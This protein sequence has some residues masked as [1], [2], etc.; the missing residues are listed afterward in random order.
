MGFLDDISIG[1]SQDGVRMV[2]AGVEKIGKTTLVSGAP[3]AIL[4]PLEIGY[5]TVN[6][7]KKPMVKN[8]DHLLKELNEILELCR[9]NQFPFQSIIFDSATALERLIHN[10][11]LNIDPELKKDLSQNNV[12]ASMASACGGFGKAYIRASEMMSNFLAICDLLAVQYKINIIFTCHVASTN[13]ID[14]IS[15]EYDSWDLVLHSNKKGSGAKAILCQWTDLLGFMHEPIHVVKANTDKGENLNKAVSANQGRVLSVTRSPAYVAGNRFNM[16]DDIPI[17]ITN[18]WNELAHSI[19][20][21]SGVNIYNME[22][23]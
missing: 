21:H 8:Y 23:Q 12:L 3:R 17:P 13:M 7:H 4:Y 6:C 5:A 14:P 19:Y 9:N 10:N 2:I 15:G 20:H 1:P 18:G 22:S 11:I 16:S